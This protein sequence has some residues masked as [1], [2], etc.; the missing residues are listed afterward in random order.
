MRHFGLL[1]GLVAV[2]MVVTVGMASAAESQA[3]ANRPTMGEITKIDGKTLTIKVTRR[4][5]STE[6][7]A[8]VDDATVITKE[9]KVKVEDVKVGD[10]VRITKGDQRYGGEVTKVD[11]KTITLKSRRG[12]D[13]S[14][15]V[16]DNTTILGE[17]KAKFEDLKVG[18]RVAATITEGKLVRINVREAPPTP[19]EK[20]AEK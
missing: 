3:P 17:A 10:R 6:Q 4:D 7:T 19:P 9:A 5:T 12:E 15:T 2:M 11:G 1:L 16:D 18:L 13:Q 8:T 20:P 14:V